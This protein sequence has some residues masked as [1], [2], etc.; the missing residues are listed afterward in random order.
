[1]HSEADSRGKILEQTVGLYQCNKCGEKF[2]HVYGRQKLKL[3]PVEKL[4]QLDKALNDAKSENQS[5]QARI[6]ALDAEGARL[7]AEIMR[8]QETIVL[9][10]LE[11]QLETLRREV[12]TLRREK[13]ELEEEVAAQLVA[14]QVLR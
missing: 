7:R 10:E 8:L 3:M 5:L 4:E 1:M 2:P 9:N 13:T 6:E 14:V 12:F 11:N